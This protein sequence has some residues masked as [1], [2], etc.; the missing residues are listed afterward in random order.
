MCVK[1]NVIHH[2]QRAG[3]LLA[4]GIR[5]FYDH[6]LPHMFAFLA[7]CL[8]LNHFVFER[9]GLLV[10]FFRSGPYILP[11]QP[12]ILHIS[13]TQKCVRKTFVHCAV[14]PAHE[15][16]YCPFNT[17][18]GRD[19]ESQCC[20]GSWPCCKPVMR[21]VYDAGAM[22]TWVD[23][24]PQVLVRWVRNNGDTLSPGDGRKCERCLC[25]EAREN[26]S[27]CEFE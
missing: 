1:C 18:Y 27:R 2:V 16:V 12:N 23:G 4:N 8:K 22:P 7:R 24:I 19:I 10:Y 20:D 9:F 11:R 6:S 26:P 13:S 14:P 5:F 17:R 21:T 15:H 3:Q 25:R